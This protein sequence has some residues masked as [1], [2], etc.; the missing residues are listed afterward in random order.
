MRS[1]PFTPLQEW[2]C[3]GPILLLIFLTLFGP[4][5]WSVLR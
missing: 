5:V 2:L 4:F 3:V 1:R